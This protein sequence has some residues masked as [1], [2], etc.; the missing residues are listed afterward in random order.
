MFLDVCAITALTRISCALSHFS[1]QHA[2][3]QWIRCAMI[4]L[5]CIRCAR[6][7][8]SSPPAH[9]AD[10]GA[11]ARWS[12]PFD[13]LWGL[14]YDGQCWVMQTLIPDDEIV[15]FRAQDGSVELKCRIL[16]AAFP[17]SRP[18]DVSDGEYTASEN[19]GIF[20]GVYAEDPESVGSLDS[21]TASHS[22]TSGS[23]T[24]ACA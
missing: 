3:S 21:D 17:E 11:M 22:S 12:I 16:G 7:S 10:P 18:G 6:C 15:V 9:C 19:S 23:D 1:T 8:S 20:Y 2:F 14:L 24:G 4:A 13:R 5:T